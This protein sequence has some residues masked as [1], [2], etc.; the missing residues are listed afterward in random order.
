MVAASVLVTGCSQW[1]VGDSERAAP[2][3]PP[4]SSLAGHPPAAPADPGAKSESPRAGAPIAEVI[5]WIEAGSPVDVGAYRTATRDGQA[6]QLGEDVAFT[7]PAGSSINCMTD[8]RSAGALACLVDLTEAPPQPAEVYG[9]WVGG[10]VDFA[11]QTLEIGSVHGDPGR[12]TR[13]TGPVLPQGR[14]LSFG[15]YRCRAESAAAV[16]VN[17]AHQS[18]A[19]FSAEA[20]EPFG[21]LRRVTPPADVGVK[22]SC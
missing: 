19:R 9:E 14:T 11:G 8:T 20:I 15:D 16:C 17:Y 18:A 7:T 21:C 1:V 12:F 6:R 13:G 22:F 4:S 3:D 10:W 5:G 2:A